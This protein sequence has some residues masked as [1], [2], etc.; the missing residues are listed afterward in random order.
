MCMRTTSERP[1]QGGLGGWLHGLKD[2]PFTGDCVSAAHRPAKEL[3]PIERRDRI[4]RGLQ[5]TAPLGKQDAVGLHHRGIDD[6][7]IA[8]RGY[9]T[10]PPNGR[11][12]L[13]NAACN[14]N[15]DDLENVPGFW[16]QTGWTLAGESGLL[17]P[18]HDP[19]GRIRAGSPPSRARRGRKIPLALLR[20]ASSRGPG[21][22]FTATLPGRRAASSATPRFGSRKAS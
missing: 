1:A 22:G 7:Q 6:R 10:L 15:F 19:L 9:R 21:A 18:C 4:Y 12:L 2:G 14:G 3:A 16:M 13:A 8:V 20:P 11:S 17:I 5:A